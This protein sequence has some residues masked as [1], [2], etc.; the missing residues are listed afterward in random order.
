MIRGGSSGGGEENEM[1]SERTGEHSPI[2]F[3]QKKY[4]WLHH[5]NE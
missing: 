2:H 1:I 3:I 4:F 5:K